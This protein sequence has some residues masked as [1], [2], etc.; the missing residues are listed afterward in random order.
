[1][2]LHRHLLAAIAAASLFGIPGIA[3]AQTETSTNLPATNPR[4]TKS[5]VVPG[6]IIGNEQ[7][8]RAYISFGTNEFM[9]ILPD[10]VLARF[11]QDCPARLTSRKDDFSISFRLLKKLPPEAKVNQELRN[12]VNAHYNSLIKVEEFTLPVAGSEGVGLQF[13]Q[14]P[15]WSVNRFVKII[16]APCKSG[17]LEFILVSD[18]QSVKTAQQDFDVVIS[19]FFT[20]EGGKIKVIPRLDR[21]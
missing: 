10:D 4:M 21:S 15:Q 13:R 1:M 6:E 14:N 9:F 12:W 17:V 5:I 3:V 19:T 18:A 2:L 8:L 16:W 20:N 7:I 11:T